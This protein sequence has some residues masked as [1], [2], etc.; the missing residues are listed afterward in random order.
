MMV[1]LVV[2]LAGA[3][4]TIFTLIP[5]GIG[6]RYV[7]HTHTHVVSLVPEVSRKWGVVGVID[8]FIVFVL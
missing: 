5:R 6:K 1:V 4:M 3:V 2:V 7:L 8:C